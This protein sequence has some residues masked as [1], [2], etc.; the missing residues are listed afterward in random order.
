[1]I[2]IPLGNRRCRKDTAVKCTRG[3]EGVRKG[4]LTEL[5]LDLS[6]ERGQGVCS[7][8]GEVR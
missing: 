6:L 2:T 4:F 7:V 3:G 8:N 5:T 1:M